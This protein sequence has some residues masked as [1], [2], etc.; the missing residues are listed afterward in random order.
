[1]TNGY[2]IQI[3]GENDAGPWKVRRIDDNKVA[4]ERSANR[5]AEL[6]LDTVGLL[7]RRENKYQLEYLSGKEILFEETEEKLLKYLVSV[8]NLR[9]N[10]VELMRH[11]ALT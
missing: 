6:C 11:F 9:V 8:H 1:M 10:S 2:R 5:F 4:E 7:G 3:E